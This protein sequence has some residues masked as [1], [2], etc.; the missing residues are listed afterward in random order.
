MVSIR[1]WPFTSI[2][3]PSRTTCCDF[4]LYSI[5][6][7]NCFSLSFFVIRSGNWLSCF[8]SGY[9]A[10]ALNRQFV[11]AMEFSFLTKIGPESRVQIRLVGHEM[12]L[13]PALDQH[14][15]SFRAFC[16]ARFSR[17]GS[18][19]KIYVFHA[20]QVADDIGEDPRDGVEFSWPVR[21]IVRP[22]QPCGL[23][24]LP[25][26]GHAV[27]ERTGRGRCN[28]GRLCTRH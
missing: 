12:K 22:R 1:P 27:A 2:L 7:V 23:V 19:D 17:S 18:H 16:A 10:Q 20:A 21:A 4:P 11:I 28:C 6:G 26:G 24:R 14:G 25:L 13:L 5:T 15:L 9:L 3:P 8:Q